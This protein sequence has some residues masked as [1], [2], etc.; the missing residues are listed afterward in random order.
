M[1]P[2]LSR[3][4]MMCVAVV[5]T[6]SAS[7]VKAADPCRGAFMEAHLSASIADI[8]ETTDSLRLLNSGENPRLRQLLEFR[9]MSAAADARRYVEGGAVVD[10]A[11]L[12]NLLPN[13]LDIVKKASDYVIE[14]QLERNPPPLADGTALK[15][16]ANLQLVKSWLSRHKG[17][18]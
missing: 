7:K 6:I 3:P 2:Y 13:W 15:P 14:H 12:A 18:M 9:L 8:S 5:I 11:A 1:S 16:L 10:P 17:M 4:V